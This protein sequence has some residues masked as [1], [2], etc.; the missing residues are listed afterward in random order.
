MRAAAAL[1]ALSV[2]STACQNNLSPNMTQEPIAKKVPK[3]L[4]THGDVRVDPYFWMNDRE[5]PEVIDYLSAENSYREFVMKETEPFQEKLYQEMIGRLVE[6]DQS[7][8]YKKRGYY[9]YTRFEKGKQY[10]IICRKKE[11]LEAPEEVLLNV[12][13]LAEGKDYYQVGSVVISPDNQKMVFSADEVSRRIYTLYVKD[14]TT[15][16]ISEEKVENV[17][18]DCV[19]ADDNQTVFY[20]KQDPETLRSYQ[21][22]SHLWGGDTPDKLVFEETDETFHI[23]VSKTKSDR[24]IIIHS[25]STKSDEVRFLAADKPG[26]SFE[27]FT[28][29]VR[30]LEYSIDHAGDQWYIRNNSGEAK[31][32]KL[33]VASENATNVSQWTDLIPHREDVFLEDIDVFKNYVVSEERSNG[34]TELI[35]RSTSSD[36]VKKL[37]I[38][39]ETYMMSIG[40]NAD[41]DSDWLRYNY[42]SLVYPNSVIDYNMKTGESV[43]QK[44]Q[45]VKGGYNPEDY[46]SERLWATARDGKK[47]PVSIVYKKSTG[48][49]SKAPLLLYAYGSYGYTIDDYFSATRL[50]LLDRGFV[51]AIAHVRG[52]QYL[53]RDWYEDGKLLN[54]KNTFTDFID[55]GKFLVES[56]YTQSDRMFAM[57]GSAGGLLMGAVLNME[58]TL[59][60]GVIAAVPFVD[61]VTTMLD[62]SIPLT[63]GEF[64]E[65]GNPK[66]SVYY[67]YMKSY[68]PY[69][70][71]AAK[72]Y[73]AILVTTGLHDSQV[74]YWEPAKWVAKLRDMRMDKSQPLLLYC[75]MDTGHG[76]ASG[77]YEAYRETAMEYTFI[78]DLIGKAQP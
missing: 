7:V 30:G 31:N 53:G 19:W 37:P 20:S 18:G 39:E 25:S 72:R 40:S 14:L 73:P 50:S 49:Q 6:D 48:K 59:F 41:Y 26:S 1:L 56:N 57:G 74:Q 23:G 45:E 21:V 22:Y 3:R 68:S 58:P 15:G 66:D 77:R 33:S 36:E 46:T 38:D 13:E 70:Q 35:I 63:T 10:P 12:N 4:E 67:D 8:P 5:D 61:V 27:I 43:V 28:P 65:W 69:D 54:K 64:D 51:M 29:R 52:G 2:L 17:V 44:R 16:E 75:N 24:F 55:C 34:L 78:L 76:G 32:F 11:S 42:S 47:V 60:R 9:Y 71:V 62:E